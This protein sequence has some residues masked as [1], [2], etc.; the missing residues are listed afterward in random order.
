MIHHITNQTD[1]LTPF[2]SACSI[3]LHYSTVSIPAAA[4]IFCFPSFHS[5][6]AARICLASTE[7]DAP[8]SSHLVSDSITV[9]AS[10]CFCF[11]LI[12]PLLPSRPSLS[13]SAAAAYSSSYITTSLS[14]YPVYASPFLYVS[15]S[16]PS[17]F[18]VAIQCFRINGQTKMQD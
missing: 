18:Y 3:L 17:L 2:Y 15:I 16:F 9:V 1:Y 4:A 8:Y 5:V 14:V 7:R 13:T 6:A 11:V 12:F 10:S